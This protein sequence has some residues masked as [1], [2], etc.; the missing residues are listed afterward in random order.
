M[1]ALPP[2]RRR[3]AD[4]PGKL[5]PRSC[6]AELHCRTNFSFLEGASHPDHLVNKAAE[7]GLTA[8]AITDRNRVAG[9]VRA[10]VAA[11]EAK[12]ASSTALQKVGS[13]S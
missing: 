5:R 11:K 12:E 6:Y 13:R 1:P 9:V 4:P 3:H 7:L 8:L 2:D 10:H